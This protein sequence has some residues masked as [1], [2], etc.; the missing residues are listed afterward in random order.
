[1]FAAAA[2]GGAAAAEEIKGLKSKGEEAAALESTDDVRY[3]IDEYDPVMTE[4]MKEF[5][6]EHYAHYKT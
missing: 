1:M 6:T 4:A 3:K 2:A 5:E